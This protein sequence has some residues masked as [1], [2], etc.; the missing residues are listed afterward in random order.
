MGSG[1]TPLIVAAEH[2]HAEVVEQLCATGAKPQR[3]TRNG[4][5]AAFAASENGHHDVERYLRDKMIEL[6]KEEESGAVLPV[7]LT[8][9]ISVGMCVFFAWLTHLANMSGGSSS[10]PKAEL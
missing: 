8:L 2:G 5:T 4:L 9:L 6:G 7:V 1:E 10:G 3:R